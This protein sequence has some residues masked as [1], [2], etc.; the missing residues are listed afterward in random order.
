[1]FFMA[2]SSNS[3]LVISRFSVLHLSY[4]EKQNLR[5]EKKDSKSFS[6]SRAHNRIKAKTSTSCCVEELIQV[7][8]YTA[9]QTYFISIKNKISGSNVA[10]RTFSFLLSK[11]G[12]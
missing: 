5:I 4:L 9:L 11:P 2:Y 7:K 8:N 10:F 12:A 6:D 3:F 1:M